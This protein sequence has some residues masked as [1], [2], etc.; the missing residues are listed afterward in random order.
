LGR[1]LLEAKQNGEHGSGA[2]RQCGQLRS[3]DGAPHS[4][5]QGVAPAHAY[6]LDRVVDMR[7]DVVSVKIQW[8]CRQD[9]WDTPRS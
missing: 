1:E 4:P 8:S 5:S 3:Q 2:T 6:S 9:P 7:L